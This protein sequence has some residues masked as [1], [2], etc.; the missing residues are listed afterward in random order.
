MKDDNCIFCKILA[1]E[2]PAAKIFEDD[3]VLAF[4]DA[5]PQSQGHALV[6]PKNHMPDVF[7]L[8]VQT[9][10]KV[11]DATQRLA[12]AAKAAFKADGIMLV[13]FNGASA[14]QS[15]FH[16]HFHVIPRFEGVPIKMHGRDWADKDELLAHAA[17]IRD[18]LD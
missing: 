14:G 10:H 15:V 11:I 17:K 18:A 5:M 4:M 2:I 6:I 3:D 1:G 13:Q 16:V 12:K 8:D 7:G 9:L